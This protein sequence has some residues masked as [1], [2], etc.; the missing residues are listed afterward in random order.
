MDKENAPLIEMIAGT[1]G[2]FALIEECE[3]FSYLHMILGCMLVLYILRGIKRHKNF[4]EAVLFCAAASLPILLTLSKPLD[5]IRDKYFRDIVSRD[6]TFALLWIVLLIILF[7][8]ERNI[9][10]KNEVTYETH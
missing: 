3:S 7:V 5:C 2:L 4:Y 6:G 10:K 8:I 1:V 9:Y